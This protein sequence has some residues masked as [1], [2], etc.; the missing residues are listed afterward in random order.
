MSLDNLFDKFEEDELED[1]IKLTPRMFALRMKMAPQ[2]VYYYIRRGII[3][4]ETCVCGRVV[5]DTQNCSKTLSARKK[6]H[7]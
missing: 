7:R 4:T 2:L 1:A 5:V 3:E 6:A